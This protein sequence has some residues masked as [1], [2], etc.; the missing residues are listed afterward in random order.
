MRKQQKMILRKDLTLTFAE[1]RVKIY[2]KPPYR[3]SKYL[4]YIN[5]AKLLLNKLCSSLLHLQIDSLNNLEARLKFRI[6]IFLE[7]SYQGIDSV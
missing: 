1:P 4:K 6:L 2:K 3:M 7:I 5:Q